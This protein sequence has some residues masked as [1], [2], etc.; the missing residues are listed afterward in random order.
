VL[1]VDDHEDTREMYAW[2]MRAAGWFVESVADGA[3][4]LVLA[5]AFAPDVIVM[6]LNLPLVDGLAVTRRLKRD[7]ETKGVPVVAITGSHWARIEVDARA[8]GCDEFVAKPCLPDE[9]RELLEA[10]VRGERD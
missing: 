6:D 7:D 10:V 1:I 5:P 3:E 9:L 4:A 8:A 2:C